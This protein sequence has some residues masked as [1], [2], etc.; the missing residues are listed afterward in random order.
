MIRRVTYRVYVGMNTPQI[1]K[2]M[3]A[4]ITH[5]NMGKNSQ[6]TP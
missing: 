6:T 2:K 5:V 4:T 1:K 3:H